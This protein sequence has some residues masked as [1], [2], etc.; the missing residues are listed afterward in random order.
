MSNPFA[1]ATVTATMV[2]LLDRVN[3]ETS[4]SGTSVTARSP[5]LART[6]TDRQLNLFLYQ[7]LPNAARRN[8]ELPVR[9]QAG[10]LTR[11][12]VLALTLNYLLTAYGLNNDDIDAHHILGHAVSLLHDRPVL[13]RDQIRATI[14]ADTRV[15][16]SDLAD[17][18]D[19]VRLTPLM[20]SSDDLFKL[21]S[22]F[23]AEYRV[24]VGYEASVVMIE[25]R[26]PTRAA[27]MARRAEIRV[28]AINRPVIESVDPQIVDP[29]GALTI[30]GRKLRGE[31]T[32]VR[33]GQALVDPAPADIADDKIRIVLPPSL[34]AGVNT[35]QVVHDVLFGS[36]PT[37]HRGLESNVL[38][39][40]I[41]PAIDAPLPSS[42][43]RGSTLTLSLAQ[44]VWRRQSLLLLLDDEPILPVWQSGD[45]DPSPLAWF[46]IPATLAPGTYLV[47]VQVEG[48]ESETI[49]DPATH[50]LVAPTI[51]VT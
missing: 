17:A 50:I 45:P 8:E 14:V 12:P 20:L 3:A 38:A 31:A 48:I 35:V 5:D 4:L 30:R 22:V 24:T 46:P 27:P 7:V 1:I 6:N 37:P 18:I 19:T 16:A 23:G 32:H 11:R 42:V 36:P 44:P 41:R 34:A 29:S 47:R 39:F 43:A 21:W 49:E 9:D 40:A 2:S 33:F 28:A 15:A 10:E 26:H 25:R 13:T 51:D